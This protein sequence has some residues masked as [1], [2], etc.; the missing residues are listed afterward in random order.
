VE[1]PHYAPASG[2]SPAY[3]LNRGPADS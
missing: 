1:D 2:N 3:F